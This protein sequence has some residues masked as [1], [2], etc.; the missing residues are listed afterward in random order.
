MSRAI[1]TIQPAAVSAAGDE[2]L[3]KARRIA[4]ALVESLDTVERALQDVHFLLLTTAQGHAR[5]VQTVPDQM[6]VERILNAV[7]GATGRPYCVVASA[8]VADG[9]GACILFHLQ[10]PNGHAAVHIGELATTQDGPTISA[11][12]ILQ[13]GQTVALPYSIAGSAQSTAP[14]GARLH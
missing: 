4:R 5:F 14:S 12:T 10:E 7:E 1:L 2:L 6:G 8:P 9:S 11:T 13:P 3:A